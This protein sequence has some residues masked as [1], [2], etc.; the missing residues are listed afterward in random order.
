MKKLD[1]YSSIGYSCVG[2]VLDVSPEVND[3]RIGDLVA[4]GGLTACHAEVV[5]VPTKLCVKLK[6]DAEFI[7]AAPNLLQRILGK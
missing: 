6:P 3:F 4:C 7:P 2:E 1:A 5:K